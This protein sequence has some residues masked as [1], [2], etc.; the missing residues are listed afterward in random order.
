MTFEVG[1]ALGMFAGVALYWILRFLALV[2][3]ESEEAAK[4]WR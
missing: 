2:W 3:L 4:R 1:F